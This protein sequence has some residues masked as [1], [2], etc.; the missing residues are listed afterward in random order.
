M[1]G[2]KE[3]TERERERERDGPLNR[4]AKTRIKGGGG[5]GVQNQQLNC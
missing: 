2:R 3:E 5:G 1:K 4:L